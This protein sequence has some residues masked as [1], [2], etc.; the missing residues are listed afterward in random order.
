M[1]TGPTQGE[2]TMIER[3]TEVE[4]EVEDPI[5]NLYEEVIGV[6]LA[7]LEIEDEEEEEVT[8][9]EVKVVEMTR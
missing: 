4:E 6:A 7:I 3:K 2:G 9:W 5:G 1:M 8:V